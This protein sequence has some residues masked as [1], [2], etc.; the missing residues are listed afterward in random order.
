MGGKYFELEHVNLRPF[1]LSDA[2]DVLEYASDPDAIRYLSWNG[3]RS[4]EDAA[5]FVRKYY[6]TIPGFYAIEDVWLHKCIGCIELKVVPRDEKV[7][8]GYVLNR[9]FWGRG[10]M[11]EVLSAAI[12]FAFEELKMNRVEAIHYGPNVASGRVMQKAGMRKEGLGIEEVKIKGN[13]YNVVHYGLTKKQW[14][15]NR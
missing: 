7:I 9:Q 1:K 10:Y 12:E 2:A 8:L 4:L 11:T 3:V 15:E 14:K 13:F 6:M 5:D